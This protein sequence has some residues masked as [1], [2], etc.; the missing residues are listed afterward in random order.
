VYDSEEALK[1][2][3]LWDEVRRRPFPETAAGQPA[4]QE[5]ALYESWLGSIVEGAL[6]R[7]G[8]LTR[9]HERLLE[10]REEEGNQALFQAATDLGEPARNYLARLLA[11]EATLRALPH[12]G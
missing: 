8:R 10:V 2:R 4:L 7:G 3:R 9:A 5:L 12:D 11:V 1:L 6:A